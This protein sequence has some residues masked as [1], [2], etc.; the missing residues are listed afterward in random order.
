MYQEVNQMSN[1]KSYLDKYESNE[2][3]TYQLI[4]NLV[5]LCKFKGIGVTELCAK[6][7]VSKM[8]ISQCKTRKEIKF[9]VLLDM[10][11][12]LGVTLSKLMTFEYAN[13][14]TNKQLHENEEKLKNMRAEVAKLQMLIDSQKKAL[15]IANM[16]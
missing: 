8:Y 11:D 14:V 10:C 1:N 7:G 4:L 12:A 3:K 15:N 16:K 5:N 13:L 2:E 6:V 9:S